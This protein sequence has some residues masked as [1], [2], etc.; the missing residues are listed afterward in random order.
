MSFVGSLV[1][2][3]VGSRNVRKTNETNMK[4]A[5]MNNE[6]NA[7]EAQ[8][9]RDFTTAEREQQNQWNLDQWNREN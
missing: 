4:I 5:Q 2:S 9:N 1:N 7:A 3:I 8:K 6:F